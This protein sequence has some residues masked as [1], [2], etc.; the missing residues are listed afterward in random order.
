MLPELA[1]GVDRFLR[2]LLVRLPPVLAVGVYSAGRRHF[3][4]RLA[5]ARPRP[6]EVPPQ[7]AR[8]LWGVPFRSPL[9]N[10]AGMFKRGEGLEL[11]Q[12]Q[13]A[14]WYLAGTTTATP[15]LG[16]RRH[17]V[18]QPFAPY[19]RSGAASNWLG[20]PNPGHGAVAAR[21][22]RRQPVAGFPVGA[23]VAADPVG[24]Q[25]SPRRRREAEERAVDG[26]I[27]GL[28]DYTR[29]GVDFL[30][31]NESCPNTEEA[32]EGGSPGLRGSALERRLERVA[33]GFLARRERPLPV[34]V[35]VA[36]DTREEQLPELLD[37]L[38]DLGFDGLDL[39]NTS[40]DHAR[41]RGAVAAAELRLYDHFTR[42][43]GGGVSGRPLKALSLASVRAAAAHLAARPGHREFHLVRTGGVEGAADLAASASSAALSGWY[44][45]YFEAFARHGHDLYRELY[46]EIL[47]RGAGSP[48]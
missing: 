23:S 21:L 3:L 22:A 45:G 38:L 32:G 5:A 39:G 17:G 40:A 33:E 16:N 44:G 7:L 36:A 6:R 43:F 27:E 19:P 30:E 24:E 10:A 20:L 1:A 25:A 46:R 42:R 28:L 26:L 41:H 35:K 29:A 37:L 47:A 4:A 2:P 31:L 18:Y 12:A 8:T 15:R 48:S 9:G 11:C 14:G 34:I 13:G